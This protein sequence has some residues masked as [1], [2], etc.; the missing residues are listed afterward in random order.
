[1]SLS[2][3][4]LNATMGEPKNIRL[5]LEYDGTRYH[6]WQRQKT[7]ITVQG[8]LEDSIRTMVGEPVVLVGSGRTDAGVHAL[9]Q[10]CNFMTRS[11]IDPDSMR[12][13]LNSLVPDD[14]FIKHMEY[15]PL[16]FHSRY[17]VKSKTYEYRIWNRKE[18]NVFLRNYSWHIRGDLDIDMMKAGLSILIGRHDFSSF[19]SSGS[20]NK[21]PVRNIL[22]AEL[23]GPSEGTL[24]LLLEADGFLRHMVRNITGTLVDLGKGKLSLKGFKEILRSP[25]RHAVVGIKKAPPQGLFLKDIRY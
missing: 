8:V 17:S 6:G 18:A 3:K 10:V 9:K 22:L 12:R 2:K 16:D 19:K 4:P 15:V 5:I 20:T 14:I 7:D 13:G 1:M 21:D 24:F 23:H 11:E 25:Q